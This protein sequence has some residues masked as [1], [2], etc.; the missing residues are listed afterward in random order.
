MFV[1]Q[2]FVQRRRGKSDRIWPSALVSTAVPATQLC[3]KKAAARRAREKE[4][5]ITAEVSVFLE[6]E[7]YSPLWCDDNPC[8]GSCLRVSPGV[9]RREQLAR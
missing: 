3:V 8:H 9:M 6:N 7:R 2:K 5:R 4:Q 1:Q